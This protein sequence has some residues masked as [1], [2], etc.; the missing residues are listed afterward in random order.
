MSPVHSDTLRM[1][2][3]CSGVLTIALITR[4]MAANPFASQT[5]STGSG[6]IEETA[7]ENGIN[8]VRGGIAIAPPRLGKDPRGV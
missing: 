6:R 5:E 8:S 4:H 1:H 7:T 2:L 3:A